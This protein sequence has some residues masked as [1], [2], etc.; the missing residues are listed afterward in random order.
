M[1][2]GSDRVR[3][4]FERFD[5]EFY[6]RLDT[7]PNYTRVMDDVYGDPRV[8]QRY[9]YFRAAWTA[10]RREAMEEAANLCDAVAAQWA[11]SASQ[12]AAAIR[13]ATPGGDKG[14][15]EG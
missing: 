15:T 1:T 8:Q 2:T 3:E 14:R 5:A 10:S 13:A 9:R 6:K 11:A 12:C 4:E 7:K